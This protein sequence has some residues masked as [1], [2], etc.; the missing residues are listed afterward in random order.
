MTRRH[1]NGRINIGHTL[2]HFEGLLGGIEV[3]TLTNQ[4][5]DSKHLSSL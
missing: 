3:V 4:A 1:S 2:Y 5:S